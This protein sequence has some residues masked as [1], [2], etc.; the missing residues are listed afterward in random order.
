MFCG[1][2]PNRAKPYEKV[3]IDV[4]RRDKKKKRGSF[5]RQRKSREFRGGL[6]RT[7][8]MIPVRLIYNIIISIK[9]ISIIVL[10]VSLKKSAGN[11]KKKTL[12]WL[13]R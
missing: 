3:G 4:G 6:E 1:T 5:R 11:K 7:A 10:L 9:I 12:A 2:E 13:E 8:G